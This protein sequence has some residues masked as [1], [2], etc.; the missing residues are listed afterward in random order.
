MDLISLLFLIKFFFVFGLVL[1][2]AEILF[3]C[4]NGINCI[5]II[6]GDLKSLYVV[7]RGSFGSE[8]FLLSDFL[9]ILVLDL[10]FIL[11]FALV[12]I[13]IIS[14]EQKKRIENL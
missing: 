12:L 8:V 14:F 13:Q 1:I 2:F 6:R 4:R 7:K 3:V 11:I 10:I 9:I 5:R